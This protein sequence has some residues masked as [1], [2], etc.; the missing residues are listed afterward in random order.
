MSL[1]RVSVRKDLASLR[2]WGSGAVALLIMRGAVWVPE[3]RFVLNGVPRERS[4][5]RSGAGSGA[6]P[7]VGRSASELSGTWVGTWELC[8]GLG[9]PWST[10]EQPGSTSA[11]S[12]QKRTEKVE[13][14]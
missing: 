6:A 4:T 9:E 7:Q 3:Q 2:M 11:I 8:A 13:V 12:Q 14:S 10:A 5:Q 1:K